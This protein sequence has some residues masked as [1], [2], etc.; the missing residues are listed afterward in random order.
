MFQ[1]GLQTIAWKA[2]DP[3]T[4]RLTYTLH[5]RR[6]GDQGWQMLRADLLDQIFVWDTTSVSDGRY[7]IRVTASDAPSNRASV[8]P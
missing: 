4:D 2:E 5:Y 1:K 7:L 6:D 3:D 8:P